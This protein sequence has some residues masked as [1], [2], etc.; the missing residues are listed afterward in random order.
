MTNS[1]R[2]LIPKLH[3]DYI[4]HLKEQIDGQSESDNTFLKALEDYQKEVYKLTNLDLDPVIPILVSL[5]SPSGKGKTPQDPVCML[6]IIIL[7]TLLKEK[8]ITKWVDMSRSFGSFFAVLAG[9]PSHKTPGVGTYYDFMKRIINGPYTPLSGN[10]TRRSEFCAKRHRRNLPKEREAKRND[11]DPNHPKAEKL[12]NDL[13]SK[14]DQPRMDDFRKIL[15]DLLFITGI[16]PSVEAGLIN[17][18][19]NLILTG[20][21]SILKSGAS[22]NGKAICSC[23]D[24]GIYKCDHDRIYTSPSAEFCYDHHHNSFEFGDRYYHLIITQGGHDY[25]IHTHMPGGNESDYTLSI[26]SV[27]RT[28]K[29]FEEHGSDMNIDIFC[30]DGHHDSYAHYKY[31][32][33]K[34]IS[35]VIPLSE[36]SKG[37]VS[38]LPG[39][40][41]VY[42]NEDGIPFCPGGDTMRLHLYNKKR[43][44]YVYTCPIKRSTHRNGRTVYVTHIDECPMKQ[45]C[46]PKSNLGPCVYIKS[47]TDPRLFPPI[48]RE[49]KKYKK[50]M[51]LRSGSERVNAYIDS[52]NIDNAHR[53]AD[54]GIIRLTLVDIAQHASIRY[55]EDLKNSSSEEIFKTI[56]QRIRDGPG[57]TCRAGYKFA[58]LK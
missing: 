25:P 18:L 26:S 44:A 23:R 50:V 46:M 49:S 47:E 55:E 31:F 3:A 39:N 21:G 12:A 2:K 32:A 41:G 15:E 33:E 42:L 34:S 45:D 6:R 22:R 53:N 14:A 16:L 51:N 36:K 10:Q 13:L 8:S 48:P 56:L 19:E 29:M 7:M 17:D 43:K 27:D 11:I 35:P 1:N 28:Q 52:Y 24:Q 9:F 5:Y 38:H 4:G 54:Y 30:G 58:A 20:D 37:V 40:K 57:K